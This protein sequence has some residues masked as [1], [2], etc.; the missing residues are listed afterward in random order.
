M[1]S[2]TVCNSFL[3]RGQSHCGVYQVL[4]DEGSQKRSY[5]LLFGQPSRAL[6]ALDGFLTTL[7]E[8]LKRIELLEDLALYNSVNLLWI[9]R[10][11]NIL[12][13]EKADR[14]ANRGS[15]GVWATP[16]SLSV[17]SCHLEELI[18][19]WRKKKAQE[20]WL[21]EPC[22]RQAKSLI[23]EVPPE[24]WVV[25]QD[26]LHRKKLRLAV[27]QLTG[28]WKVAYHLCKKGLMDKGLAGLQVGA[29][30]RRK[31]QSTYY[32][33]AQPGLGLDTAFQALQS[34]NQKTLS[35]QNSRSCFSLQRSSTRDQTRK[36]R[37][38][39]KA[40]AWYSGQTPKCRC[41]MSPKRGHE[42]TPLQR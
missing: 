37:E 30:Q 21:L 6:M 13:N 16:C 28:H 23:G 33:I 24:P 15:K 31:L 25:G 17:P 22:L 32:A 41:R 19:A 8:V 1:Q 10:Y 5:C 18:K 39:E 9:P 35:R 27:G 4:L 26:R 14:L 20:R 11:Q 3:N 7:K 29:T 12:G 2:G 38:K 40:G 34:Y 36:R 42:P